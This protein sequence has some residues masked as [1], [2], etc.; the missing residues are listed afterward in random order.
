MDAPGAG[1]TQSRV[2]NDAFGVILQIVFSFGMPV[3]DFKR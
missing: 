2:G 1:F 3:E